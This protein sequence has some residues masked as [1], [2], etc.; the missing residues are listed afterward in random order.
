SLSRLSCK[1]AVS[2][3][4]CVAQKHEKTCHAWLRITVHSL[5]TDLHHKFPDPDIFA[6]D[7]TLKQT[8]RIKRPIP[9][10]L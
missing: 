4:E 3:S 7:M 2:H 6:F 10:I 1:N 5:F 9:I 8:G